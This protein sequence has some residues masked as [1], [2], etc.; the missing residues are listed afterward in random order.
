MTPPFAK[1]KI[2]TASG[3]PFDRLRVPHRLLVPVDKLVVPVDKLV[4]PFDK[5]VVPEPVEGQEPPSTSSWFLSLSDN[6]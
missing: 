1:P 3:N 5:L 2:G 6:Y 4:V